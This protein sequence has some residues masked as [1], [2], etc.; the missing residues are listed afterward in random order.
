MKE[1]SQEEFEQYIRNV[2]DGKMSRT[3]IA[4]E[5]ESDFRTLNNE[6]QL[7]SIKN[8]ELYQ[9]FIGK[10]PYKPKEIKGISF[11]NI[12]IEFLRGEGTWAELAE[13]YH[14]GIRTIRRKIDK[15]RDSDD[16]EEKEIYELCRAVADNHSHDTQNSDELEYRISKLEK[17]E[18]KEMDDLERRRI[19]LREIEKQYY[20]L[21]QSMS[22]T[23]AAKKMG[24]TTNRIY[25][26]LNELYRIEIEYQHRPKETSRESKREEF[27]KG[28]EEKVTPINLEDL[29][30]NQG[31]KQI[32]HEK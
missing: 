27:I 31:N 19:E 18:I 26:L 28:I 1:I 12:A 20:M 24:Y 13:K 3:Q 32:E 25:K 11:R 9:E 7:L 5:L 29:G 21:C 17:E 16:P 2:I 22:K 8:P 14:I 23:E 30:T 15:Y 6:I 10:F 4:K